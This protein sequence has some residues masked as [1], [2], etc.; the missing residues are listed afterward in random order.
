MTDWEGGIT[1]TLRPEG[2]LESLHFLSGIPFVQK[3]LPITLPPVKSLQ[4]RRNL[5]PSE[6]NMILTVASM[7]KTQSETIQ[8]K[9]TE[10]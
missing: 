10:R 8:M 2:T 7:D 9:A 6:G 5:T 1:S 3:N 4:Q